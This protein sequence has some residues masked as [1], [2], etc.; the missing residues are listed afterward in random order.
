MKTT[1]TT[2]LVGRTCETCVHGTSHGYIGVSGGV[3]KC[4]VVHCTLKNALAP[5]PYLC[6]DYSDYSE[7]RSSTGSMFETEYPATFIDDDR[8]RALDILGEPDSPHAMEE[9]A[10]EMIAL[11][12]EVKDL[13]DAMRETEDLV[14]KLDTELAQLRDDMIHKVK[15]GGFIPV[16]PIGGKCNNTNCWACYPLK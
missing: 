9:T 4:V 13:Y 2:N 8:Q 16:P 10:M 15:S 5:Q 11:R 7:S 6:R 14:F 12:I 1:N 3:Q